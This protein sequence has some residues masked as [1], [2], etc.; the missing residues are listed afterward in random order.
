VHQD[1]AGG[2]EA[3]DFDWVLHADGDR[4]EGSDGKGMRPEPVFTQG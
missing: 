4:R 1:G 2:I 3:G